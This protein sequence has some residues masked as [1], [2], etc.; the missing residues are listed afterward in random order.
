[1]EPHVTIPVGPTTPVPDSRSS[2]GEAF[3]DVAADLSTLMR[4]EVDLAKAEVRQS[5]LRAGKGAGLLGGAGVAGH[6]AVLFVSIAA[7][8]GI[9]D[10]IGHGWSALIVAAV[11]LVIAAVLA[12]IGRREITAI[13]G[14]PQTTQTV[15]KIPDA[16]KGNEG[17][18]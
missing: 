17:T 16:V 18:S 11:W 8:W 2:V 10:A 12:L 3:S 5:A 1:M 4:Q 7:W 14:V 6:L 13:S 9:G 15:K